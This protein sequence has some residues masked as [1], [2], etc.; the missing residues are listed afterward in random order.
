MKKRRHKQRRSNSAIIHV[1]IRSLSS[2]P[3]SPQTNKITSSRSTIE[4]RSECTTE[5]DFTNRYDLGLHRNKQKK[6]NIM[7]WMFC[8][9]FL[10]ICALLTAILIAML[11]AI[12]L[13]SKFLFHMY[14]YRI[15][16]YI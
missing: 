14:S 2:S 10:S 6:K 11:V 12:L 15:C 3:P 16:T 4:K 9:K 8:K 1:A 5:I 13:N 7:T